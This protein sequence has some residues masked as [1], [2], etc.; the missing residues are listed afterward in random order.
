MRHY[1]ITTLHRIMNGLMLKGATTADNRPVN[2]TATTLCWILEQV[3]SQLPAVVAQAEPVAP[4]APIAAKNSELGKIENSEISK[5]EKTKN[6][7]SKI[8]D[9]EI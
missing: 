2:S 8:P 4:A 6:E 3:E 9:L 7:N 5:N 1:H